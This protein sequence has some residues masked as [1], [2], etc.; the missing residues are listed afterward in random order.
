MLI[1]SPCWLLLLCWQ[2]L[3]LL[4]LDTGIGGI[5]QFLSTVVH[6]TTLH[7]RRSQIIRSLLLTEHLQVRGGEGRGGGV[8]G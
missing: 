3:D 7:R 5:E 1:P 4:P 2:V 6:D 8:R